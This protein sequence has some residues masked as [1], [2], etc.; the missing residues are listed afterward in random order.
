MYQ[1]LN[2]IFSYNNINKINIITKL[3]HK[4]NYFKFNTPIDKVNIFYEWQRSEVVNTR[5]SMHII[6]MSDNILILCFLWFLLQNITYK[7]PY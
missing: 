7:T 2:K 6:L 1:I 3:S 4:I 5:R